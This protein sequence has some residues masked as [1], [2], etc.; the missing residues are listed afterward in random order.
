MIEGANTSPF[1]QIAHIARSQGLKGELKVLF[2]I[3]SV[4]AIEQILVVYLRSDRGDF[5][6]CRIANLRV[7]GKGN[8]ISF[9]VQFENIADRTSAEAL[10]NKAVFIE[11][12]LAEQLFSDE[13]EEE[14]LIDYEILN[15]RNK[16]IGLVIDFMD[17]GAQ[18]V[19]T[20]ATNSGSLLI[21]I[22]DEF[23]TEIDHQTKIIRCQNLAVLEDL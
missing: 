16:S 17:S 21:P 22:V 20:V 1:T 9:F 10:K 18:V 7:E 6:P 12:T 5:Y 23:V 15:D 2:E 14:N 8:K 4:E 3:D 13:A 19:V 11:T